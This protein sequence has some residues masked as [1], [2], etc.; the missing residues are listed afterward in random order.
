MDDLELKTI[1]SRKVRESVGYL[2]S[3]ITRERQTNLEYYH[4]EPFGNEIE[5][6]SQVVSRDVMDTI[7]WMLPTFMQMFHGSENAVNFTPTGPEDEGVAD[8][9]T[10]YINYIYNSDNHGFLVTYTWFKDGLIQKLGVVKSYVETVESAKTERYSGLTE[11]EVMLILD[12]EVELV[13][14]E[15]RTEEIIDPMSGQPLEVMVYDLEVKRVEEDKR[16]CVTNI[17]PEEF[18]IERRART[19]D[20]ARFMAHRTQKTRS[21]LIEDGYPVDVINS[22]PAFTGDDDSQSE[23][24]SDTRYDAEEYDNEGPEPTDKS[25][26][27]IDV[28]EAIIHVDYDDDGVAERRRVVTAGM[29]HVILSNEAFDD[30]LFRVFSPIPMP[31]TVWGMAVADLVRDIQLLKSTVWRGMMDGLYQSLDPMKILVPDAVG[32]YMDDYT[33]PATPGKYYR[34][35]RPDAVAFIPRPWEG[36]KGFTMLEYLDKIREGRAGVSQT[37]TGTNPDLLQNQTATAVNQAMTAAQMRVELIARIFAETAFKPLMRDLL[38]LTTKYQDK[39]RVIRLRNDW[40]PVDPRAWN[41]DMDVSINVGLGT[42]NKDQQ[43]TYLMGILQQQKEAIM[44]PVGSLMVTPSH[45]FNTLEQMTKTAGFPSVDA[46]FRDPNSQEAQMEAQQR[47]QQPDPMQQQMQM[48]AQMELMKLRLDQWEAER[49]DDRK[50]DELEADYMIKA[51]EIQAKYGTQVNV[52]QI[53]AMVDR[54]RESVRQG[55]QMVR[56]AVQ[57]RPQAQQPQQPPQR[58]VG[59]MQ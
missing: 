12:D 46:F 14:Q 7:E 42:G 18:V 4:G 26:D 28:T 53:K 27:L 9:A 57:P 31:H 48:M 49:E 1:I 32:P 55:A 51:A 37:S 35:E 56:E 8:Q 30:P 59:G 3:E 23:E 10:D 54:D 58:A 40:V 47:A 44:S 36:Q 39:E 50:R 43:M 24:E 20:D 45:I 33:S 52:A 25:T 5:G 13:A 34:A 15:E 38:K 2:S 16:I 41:A 11:D 17:P 6:R 29:E 19:L 21:E 22:L